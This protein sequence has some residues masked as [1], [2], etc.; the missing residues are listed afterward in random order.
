[1]AERSC[2]TDAVPGITNDSDDPMRVSCHKEGVG[3]DDAMLV[4]VC[5]GKPRAGAWCKDLSGPPPIQVA[6]GGAAV[7]L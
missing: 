2:T 1:M 4:P 5:G 6:L 3:V 7:R